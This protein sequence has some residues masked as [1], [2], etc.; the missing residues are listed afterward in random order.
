MKTV[1]ENLRGEAQRL[2]ALLEELLSS[3]S[4]RRWHDPNV[5]GFVYVGGPFA[6]NDLD[7]RGLQTQA[8]ILEE[9][10]R[11]FSTLR[12]L[13]RPKNRAF[14]FLAAVR[15]GTSELLIPEILSR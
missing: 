14:G 10:R 11:F 1:L 7:Q 6:W 13:L 4:I 8:K 15:S 5:D 2:R 3:S 12:T 9:Y